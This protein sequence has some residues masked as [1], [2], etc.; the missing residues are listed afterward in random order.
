MI[1]YIRYNNALCIQAIK[2]KVKKIKIDRRGDG[3]LQ[4]SLIRFI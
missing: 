3:G 2:K 1:Q 4:T